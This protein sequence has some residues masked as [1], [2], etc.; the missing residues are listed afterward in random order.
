MEMEGDKK[1]SVWLNPLSFHEVDEPLASHIGKK[2]SLE[3]VLNF[4]CSIDVSSKLEDLV[5]RYKEISKEPDRLLAPPV[6]EKILAKLVWPLRHAKASYVLGN[7]LGT[8]ALCGMVSEMVA[9][10][11]W[12]ISRVSIN[13]KKMEPEDEKGIF[14][15]T[16]E[17]LGQERRVS[18]LSTY[19]LI[20]SSLVESFDLIRSKRRTYLHF[21]SADYSQISTDAIRVFHATVTVVVGAIGQGVKDGKLVLNIALLKY[22]EE[23]GLAVQV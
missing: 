6:E 19:N 5:L 10:L 7:Y 18:I 22:L 14:G 9:L 12:E 15:S 3:S 8:I 11:L 13:G 20:N 4:L 1:I 2:P 16:F 21:Y 23:K 17:K